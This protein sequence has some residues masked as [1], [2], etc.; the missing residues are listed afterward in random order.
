[1]LCFSIFFNYYCTVDTFHL[2]YKKIQLKTLILGFFLMIAPKERTKDSYLKMA[3][4]LR[5]KLTF[6]DI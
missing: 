1:M 4:T 3:T 5:T 2:Q 6:Y